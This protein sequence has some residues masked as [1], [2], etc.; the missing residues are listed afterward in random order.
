MSAELTLYEHFDQLNSVVE[1]YLKGEHP[2]AIAKSLGLKRTLVMELIDEFRKYAAS[3]RHIS[4]RAREALVGA[5]KHYSMI[6]ERGWE[7]VEQADTNSDLRTKNAA[8]GLVANVEQKRMEMLQ[9]AGVLD[10]TELAAQLA[11]AEQKQQSL[12]EILK[13]LCPDCKARVAM[14]LSRVSGEAVTVLVKDEPDFH[15]V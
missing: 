1:K 9:K 15:D 11:D 14:K 8:L 6:I 12:I 4:D 2:N 13:D 7:T 3:N 5:D 10:N